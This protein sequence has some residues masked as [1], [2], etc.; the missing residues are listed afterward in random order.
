MRVSVRRLERQAI[1]PQLLPL[2]SPCIM[3]G[4]FGVIGGGRCVYEFNHI[5]PVELAD[6]VAFRLQPDILYARNSCRH[7]FDPGNR[8][9]LIVQRSGWPELVSHHVNYGCRLAEL[10]YGRNGP[11]NDAPERAARDKECAP[12][13]Q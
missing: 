9:L 3:D 7:V 12:S 5:H 1:F 2:L 8:L 4:I 13:Q 6:L 11:R 10:V